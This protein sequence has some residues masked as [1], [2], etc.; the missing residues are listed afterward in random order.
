MINSNPLRHPLHSEL[1]SNK[2]FPSKYNISI[3]PDIEK[4]SF[5]GTVSVNINILEPTEEITLHSVDLSL[6]SVEVHIS[7]NEVLAPTVIMP[8]K[9]KETVTLKFENSLPKCNAILKIK[10]S[11]NIGSNLRGLYL[12]KY[13][14]SSQEKTMIST[15]FEPTDARRMFP[16]WDEPS[17]K[18]IFIIELIIPQH[19]EGLSNMPVKSIKTNKHAMKHI[20][21]DESP[22]MSTYILA[23]VI[24]ELESISHTTE[25]GT[26]IS[27]W[28]TKGNKNLGQFALDTSTRLLEYM[29]KYFGIPYPLKKLDHIVIPDFAAGAMENWGL[30]T[31]RETALL[32]DPENS[33]VITRQNVAAIIAHEMAHMWF[34]N[35]VTM[36]WWND[37]WLNESFASW[38]GDKAIN[39]IFPEWDVWTNFVVDD[40]NIALELDG[41][42]NSHPIE[43]E[44][45]NPAEIGQLF[46]AIS[47]S[48][49]ASILRMLEAFLSPNIFQ[50]GISLY[51]KSHEYSNA[52]TTDLWN[53][54]EIISKKPVQTIMKDWT[55]QTGYPLINIKIESAESSKMELSIN[56]TPFRYDAIMKN[57]STLEKQID[58]N[59]PLTIDSYNASKITAQLISNKNNSLVLDKIN[60]AKPYWFKINPQQTGF[61]RVN[62][63]RSLLPMQQ[64]MIEDK[65]I[66]PVDR[67]GIQNDSHALCLNGTVQIDHLLE[68]LKFY[69]NE[70]NP[71]V[72]MNISKNIDHLNHLLAN[73]PCKD[74]M[75]TFSRQMFSSIANTLGWNPT[76]TDTDLNVI[77]RS[78]ILLRLGIYGD[79]TT[80][81]TAR[82][83]FSN[84][85]NKKTT[86]NPD[87]RSVVY[88]LNTKECSSSEYDEMLDLYS[89][90]SLSEERTRILNALTYPS[91]SNLL[92][93]TLEFS[94]TND[95]R[96]HDTIRIIL[97][98]SRNTNSQNLAWEFIKNNWAELNK[99]YGKGGFG[100]MSL[101]SIGS[102]FTQQNDLDDYMSFFNQNPVPSADRAI[103]QSIE[104]STLNIQWLNQNIKSTT[105][106]LEY[107]L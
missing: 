54:L 94:L 30:I 60:D 90:A 32:V 67:L 71:H 65:L 27:I 92:K 26:K 84:F 89:K 77:L 99:R 86:I 57:N 50:K 61:Y 70:T 55:A 103:K 96:Q 20:I 104:Q 48:K 8:N 11:G 81:S 28:T 91:N 4:M 23:I 6:I 76:E 29:N 83:I 25:E 100:I 53:A 7:T 46:D 87:I 9:A 10:F 24:G 98:V 16:C 82:T 31:Y 58:W 56:Q 15:Q 106:W 37:L 43:Q 73:T 68:L 63:D 17:Y 35:L 105:T 75:E 66:S 33:S 51:M 22:P 42:A 44:V 64:K 13:K 102:L 69:K 5:Q 79:S 47:Y 12:S 18:A 21:F 95:V 3:Q 34:G 36:K 52:Q 62:Y 41:L 93:K 39:D 80:V 85:R 45:N 74:N 1:L 2:I 107:N 59:I 40:T 72:W 49:G 38:M 101:V 14:S 97:G 88:N 78:N 19:L